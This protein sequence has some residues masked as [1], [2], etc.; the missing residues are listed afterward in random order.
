MMTTLLL[1]RAI[2]IR[3]IED[4][5]YIVERTLEED[6][7]EKMSVLLKY[8]F[9]AHFSDQDDNSMLHKAQSGKM[10]KLLIDK[11]AD[12]NARNK[13]GDTPLH[14]AVSLLSKK[15]GRTRSDPPFSGR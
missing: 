10:A 15:K 11:G 12:V 8:K 9:D 6:Q 7:V 14:T 4:K 1:K 13:W 2:N 3:S 5:G